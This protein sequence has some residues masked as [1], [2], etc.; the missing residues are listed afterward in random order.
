MTIAEMEAAA[1]E[2]KTETVAKANTAD[3]VGTLFEG[4]VE[5]LAIYE[6]G[7]FV[8]NAAG[9][10]I[11]G[12]DV[13]IT[14]EQSGA[15]AIIRIPTTKMLKLWQG[16]TFKVDLDDYSDGKSDGVI[17][18]CTLSVA[19]RPLYDK[20]NCIN[21]N[22]GENGWIGLITT[23]TSTY[24]EITLTQVGIGLAITSQFHTTQQ[25]P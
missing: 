14:L 24:F 8:L 11:T 5:H 12:S 23:I 9:N 2:I 10:D 4:I 22:D 6:S 19:Y 18:H 7:T 25:L 21:Y 17:Q 13:G 20:N 15:T 1:L 16:L 3:R